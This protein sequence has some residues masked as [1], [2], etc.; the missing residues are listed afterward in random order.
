MQP[1][2]MHKGKSLMARAFEDFL[3]QPRFCRIILN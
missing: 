2:D 3:K 1:F